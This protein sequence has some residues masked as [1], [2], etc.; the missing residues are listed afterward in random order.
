MYAIIS[1]D[2]ESG[3]ARYEQ[4]KKEFEHEKTVKMTGIITKLPKSTPKWSRAL[5]GRVG[6]AKAHKKAAETH[7][8]VTI[9]EDDVRLCGPLTC[10][11]N[12]I[13][14]SGAHGA[15]ALYGGTSAAAPKSY[16]F[17]KRA[18]YFPVP[19]CNCETKHYVLHC[20]KLAGFFMYNLISNRAVQLLKSTPDLSKGVDGYFAGMLDSRGG[21]GFL[22][23]PFIAK[24]HAGTSCI[25]KAHRDYTTLIDNAEKSYHSYILTQESIQAKQKK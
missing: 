8:H 25:H 11:Q 10:W 12:A 16:L 18:Q 2:N 7:P 5:E 21:K 19:G 4:A 23:V 22:V 14:L 24:C 20:N 15:D 3:R 6:C 13:A 9:V 1:C 17:N